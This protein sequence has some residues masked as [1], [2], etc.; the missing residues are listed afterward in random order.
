MTSNAK[1]AGDTATEWVLGKTHRETANSLDISAG[2]VG[3]SRANYNL[4]LARLFAVR[5]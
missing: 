3:T 2:K 4:G 1:S 5:M